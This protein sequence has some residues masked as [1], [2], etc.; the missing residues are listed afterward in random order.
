MK[1][2]D[3]KPVCPDR[4]QHY[5]LRR[6][7]DTFPSAFIGEQM[8][9]LKVD[10]PHICETRII[11]EHMAIDKLPQAVYTETRTTKRVQINNN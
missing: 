7:F 1:Y 4:A 11:I 5:H 8:V 9:M 10:N 6:V 2:W 3:I